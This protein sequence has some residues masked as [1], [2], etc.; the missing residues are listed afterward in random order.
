MFQRHHLDTLPNPISPNDV[1]LYKDQLQM[2][3]NVFSFIDD[4][5]RARHPLVISRKNHERV[6]NLL[7]WKNQY[8]PI[9]NIYRLFRDLFKGNRD[10][11]IL[12]H[13][14]GHFQTKEVLNRHKVLCTRD[15]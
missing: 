12:L 9:A 2:N 4:E 14:L 8:A 13:C 11:Q 3:I 5:G 15:D 1:H 6:A 7:Y 10:H